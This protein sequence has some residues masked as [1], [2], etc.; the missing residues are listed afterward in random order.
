MTGKTANLAD[1]HKKS[2]RNR[3][4]LESAAVCACFY[5]F[6]EYSYDRIEEWIDGGRTALCPVC[7][8]DAVL[9]FGAQ[10]VDRELLRKMHERWFETPRRLT[11]DE[12][13]GAIEED[14]WPSA[15]K[16]NSDSG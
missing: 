7:G 8:V 11:A 4:R 1:L 9:G 13:K 10:P 14:A 16:G 15:L 6:S 5:C 3:S 12:W 2:R